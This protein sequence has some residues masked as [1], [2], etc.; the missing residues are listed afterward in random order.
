MNANYT[1]INGEWVLQD[2]ATL[3]IS[4]LSIQRGYGI[5]DFLKMIGGKPLF[6][7]DHLDRFFHSA[8][9]M[10]LPVGISREALKAVIA[11]MTD[12][13]QLRDAGIRLTLT[14]GY[15]PDAYTP[16]SPNLII[17]QQP[18]SIPS[19]SRGIAII[20]YEHQRQLP[21]VKTID[22]L[23]AIW[24]QPLV[25]QGEA[26][27]VLYHQQDVVTELPRANFYI[28]TANGEIWTPADNILSGVIR[29]QLLQLD[30]R[31]FTIQ[32]KTFTLQDVKQAKEAFITSTTK[33]ILPIL[34]ID[35]IPVG[36]GTPGPVT[37]QLSEALHQL[38]QQ[39]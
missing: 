1:W 35:G 37:Q 26:Q 4:D 32:A 22:Y 2:Q 30:G 9:T 11:E 34:Q 23:M 24:L 6:F 15:A 14:G 8:S 3:H 36:N 21:S 28:V 27:D 33:N 16:A 25:A 31:G 29:K 39:A 12:R 17:T 18:L 7:D 10:H 20:T 5:F 13:N 19:L 38:L